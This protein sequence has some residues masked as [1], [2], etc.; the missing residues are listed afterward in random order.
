MSFIIFI[1]QSA[2]FESEKGEGSGLDD[3]T[4]KK[5]VNSFPSVPVD[6]DDSGGVSSSRQNC[7]KSSMEEC[8]LTL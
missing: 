1:V 5:S 3:F 8:T 4:S 6:G 7:R 2:F